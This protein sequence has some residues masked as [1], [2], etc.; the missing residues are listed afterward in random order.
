MVKR[1]LFLM[2]L[3]T[4]SFIF[5]MDEV[6]RAEQEFSKEDRTR[7][8]LRCLVTN[9]PTSHDRRAIDGFDSV[10]QSTES[11]ARRGEIDL[12]TWCDYYADTAIKI[13]EKV[14][15]MKHRREQ[16]RECAASYTVLLS[17]QKRFYDLNYEVLETT[18][19]KNHGR[20]F[21]Q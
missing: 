9:F 4:T 3:A 16:S 10:I 21:E 1:A 17:A 6:A 2:S 20:G 18:M 15:A 13:G 19:S 14:V 7:N 11:T 5:S 8:I 12:K